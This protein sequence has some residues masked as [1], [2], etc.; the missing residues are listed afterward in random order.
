MVDP[1]DRHLVTL[2][3]DPI[4][5]PECPAPRRPSVG[6]FARQR[7]ANATWIFDQRSGDQVDHCEGNSRQDL[8]DGAGGRPG[9]DEFV[10]PP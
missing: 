8:G 2:V 1:E 10:G 5:H 9:D 3:V 7:L 6:E 4:E